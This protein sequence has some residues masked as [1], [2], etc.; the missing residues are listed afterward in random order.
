MNKDSSKYAL[1][2]NDVELTSLWNHCLSNKTGEKVFKEGMPILLEL[3][4][5]YNIKAT[6]F[7]TGDIAELFPDIV[8]M[9]LPYGHEIGCHGYTHDSKLAFDVLNLDDQIAHLSRAKGIL[10]S[11]SGSEVISFRAPALRVNKFTPEALIQTGFKI[12]SSIAPQRIDTF[13]S[14]GF[15]NKIYWVFSPREPFFTSKD[16]LAKRGNSGIFEIPVSSL[17]FSYSGTI[18]RLSPILLNSLRFFLHLETSLLKH[19]LMFLTHPNEFINEEIDS[20]PIQ[21]RSKNPFEYLLGD[22]LRYKLKLRNLGSPSTQLFNNQLKFLSS[23][24]YSFVS[25]KEYYAIY[26]KS[27]LQ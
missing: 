19:P 17:F 27:H 8:R 24:D 16:N 1:M 3:Y 2:T 15:K 20:K 11:I 10:E 23:K 9:I 22:K 5:K 18:M 12:D 21:R 6:F 25:L 13:M 4:Q 7:F 26:C 14:F